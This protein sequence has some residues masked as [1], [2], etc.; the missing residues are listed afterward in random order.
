MQDE[1]SGEQKGFWLWEV[2]THSPIMV[3]YHEER[4]Q[5]A[6]INERR[7]RTIEEIV[8]E[9]KCDINPFYG[10]KGK[11]GHTSFQS[12]KRIV[13]ELLERYSEVYW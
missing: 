2:L 8:L 11:I 7:K 6:E 3:G 12:I 5:T 9:N 1:E 10:L 13:Q 4:E